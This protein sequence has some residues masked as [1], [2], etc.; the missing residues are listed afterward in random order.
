MQLKWKYLLGASLIGMIVSTASAGWSSSHREAP[1]TAGLPRIDSTDMYMF[2]SYEPGREKFVTLIANYLPLQD[3]YGGPNYFVLDNDAVYEI[4]VDNNGDAVED[5]TFQFRFNSKL[6]NKGKGIALNIGGK[7]W[8]SHCGR[9]TRSP[10]ER[11]D[12]ERAGKL[13]AQAGR[14]RPPEWQEAGHH[15]APAHRKFIKPVDNIGNKT[16]PDYA[17][18]A[19]QHIYAIKVPG[20]GTNGRVF[21]GQRAEAFAVNLGEIFDLVN[22][23]PIEGDSAPGAGDGKGFPGGIT[24]DRANDDVVGKANVT[25]LALELP[26]ACLVG[27][28]NGVIGAWTTASL[29]QRSLSPDDAWQRERR[30]SC[31]SRASRRR[32][33][34]RW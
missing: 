26:I 29:P 32:W 30:R 15:P 10:T 25:S 4:H 21:V 34:T 28:G 20:C 23:V 27:K 33:S 24:Q 2:R 7:D 1:G 9:S 5:L 3:P 6:A 31:R 18:Y 17:A 12:A 16:L 14:G 22:F 8:R 13:H 11:R 19:K